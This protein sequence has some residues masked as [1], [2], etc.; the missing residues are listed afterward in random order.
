[1][2]DK[3]LKARALDRALKQLGPDALCARLNAPPELIQTWINGHATMPHRKFLLLVDILDE[4][5]D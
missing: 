4:I 5:G 3:E 2:V 1:M